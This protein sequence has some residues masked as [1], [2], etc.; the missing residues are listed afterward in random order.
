VIA[1]VDTNVVLDVML[2][3]EPHLAASSAVFAAVERGSCR[4]LLC[5][6]TVTTINY[7]ARRQIGD[8][9]SLARI[10]EL[11]SLF[12]IA[13]VNQAVLGSAIDRGMADFEDGV[14]REAAL[15][16][17]AHCIVTRNVLDFGS[18]EIVV[19]SP[20]QFLAALASEGAEQDVSP[21]A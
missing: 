8:R 12:G 2:G 17:G 3:R 16:A 4:G 7:I 21:K 5:A 1:L 14:L 10:S 19:Y 13:A 6:T 9:A 15:Q 11:M 20:E 18:A